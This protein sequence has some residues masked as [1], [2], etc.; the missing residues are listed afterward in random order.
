MM[1]GKVCVLAVA[2]FAFLESGDQS[3]AGR[4]S[5]GRGL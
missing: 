2:S 3:R 4:G 1:A 5:E